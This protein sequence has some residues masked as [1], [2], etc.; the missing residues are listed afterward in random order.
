MTD[1]VLTSVISAASALLVA[2]AGYVF[3]KRAEREARWRDEKLAHY[4]EFVASLSGV[5]ENETTPEGQVRFAK[6]CND[7]LLF[8]PQ[9]VIQ[10]L[11]EFHDEIRISNPNKSKERHDA[12]LARLLLETRRDIGIRPADDEKSFRVHLWASG[13]PPRDERHRG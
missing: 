10:T 3:T 13:V 6:A 5:I 8:A 2:V 12:L 11:D 1:P 4:K 7:V 9:R